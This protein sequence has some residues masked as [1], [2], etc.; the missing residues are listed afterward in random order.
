MKLFTRKNALLLTAVIILLAA[1]CAFALSREQK[2]L[3]VSEPALAPSDERDFMSVSVEAT[4][5]L[6]TVKGSMCLTATNRTGEDLSEIVLRAYPNAIQQGSVTLYGAAVN[7]ES[8]PVGMDSGDPSVWRIQTPWRAGETL[9]ISW[10]AALIVPRGESVIGRTDES[11]LLI[12]A[13]P[14]PAVWENGAWRT[15]EYDELAETSYGQ[16]VDIQMALTVPKTVL[17]AFGGAWIDE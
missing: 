13:L 6:R 12:G 7:G 17:A 2:A 10:Q 9:E 5:D 14:L 11:A 3:F 4:G 16:A 8:V 15:D 1:A